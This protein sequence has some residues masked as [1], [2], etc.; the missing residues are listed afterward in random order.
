MTELLSQAWSPGA[1]L[2]TSVPWMKML[3]REEDDPFAV[4]EQGAGILNSIDL[5]NIWSCSFLATDDTGKVF[6]DG[7]FEVSGR[8]DNSDIR[9]CSLL[10][11]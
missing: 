1:G 9:G 3:V 8:V 11:T 4:R 5:A 10:V 2:F 6:A 7:R